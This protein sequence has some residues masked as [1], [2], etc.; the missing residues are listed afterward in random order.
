MRNPWNMVTTWMNVLMNV[1]KQNTSL[2]SRLALLDIELWKTTWRNSKNDVNT[3]IIF[4]IQI[5]SRMSISIQK[6]TATGSSAASRWRRPKGCSRR[7]GVATRGAYWMGA[8]LR[9]AAEGKQGG[10]M[11]LIAR[12]WRRQSVANIAYTR[13]PRDIIGKIGQNAKIRTTLEVFDG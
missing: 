12:W 3:K 10:R 2:Q 11:Q 4:P 6:W 9:L 1:I 7:T 5:V 13:I 8:W